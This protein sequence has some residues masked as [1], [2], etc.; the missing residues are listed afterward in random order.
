M[1]GSE[2]GADRSVLFVARGD[3]VTDE[4]D[5]VLRHT[6]PLRWRPL[7][8]KTIRVH[9]GRVGMWISQ[10]NPSCSPI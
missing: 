5:D 3:S 4:C 2:H 9:V 10:G 7:H 8:D 1:S 6:I